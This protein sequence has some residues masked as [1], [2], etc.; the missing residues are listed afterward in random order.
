M[1]ESMGSDYRA[2]PGTRIGHVHL[3][4]AD[5]NRSIAF[6]RDALGFELQA[7]KAD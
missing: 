6:Y 7:R 1:S 2:S 5:V 4:V 3:R